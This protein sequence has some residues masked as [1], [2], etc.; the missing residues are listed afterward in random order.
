MYVMC[1]GMCIIIFF[2]IVYI[3]I[4]V[5]IAQMCG[6]NVDNSNTVDNSNNSAM[7]GVSF[8]KCSGDF[9]LPLT[10]SLNVL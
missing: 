3:Y 6:G 8:R 7:C 4:L 10:I 9:G 2:Y 5:G 1:G